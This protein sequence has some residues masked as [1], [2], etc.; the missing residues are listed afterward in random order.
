MYYYKHDGNILVSKTEYKGMPLVSEQE[1]AVSDCPLFLLT[2]LDPLFSRAKH[3]VSSAASAF[4][5]AE[6]IDML[7]KSDSV[8]DLPQWLISRISEGKVSSINTGYPKWQELINAAVPKKWRIN[9]IGLGD[10]GG[11]LVTGLRLLGGD[12]IENSTL[13]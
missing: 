13:R 11:I 9:V 10:V 8:S 3:H 7:Y 1:A 2:K 4:M 12:V 5:E 6:G